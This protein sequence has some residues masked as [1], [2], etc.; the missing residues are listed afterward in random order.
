MFG[1]VSRGSVGE[2]ESD[3]DVAFFLKGAHGVVGPASPG[4]VFRSSRVVQQVFSGL[5]RAFTSFRAPLATP[6]VR[7]VIYLITNSATKSVGVR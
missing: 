2:F 1:L 4:V 3:E 6:P 7:P 5:S